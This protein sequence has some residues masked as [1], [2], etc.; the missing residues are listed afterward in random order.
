MALTQ[1][2]LLME[3][4]AVDVLSAARETPL[5]WAVQGGH[6]P[7]VRTLLHWGAK[8]DVKNARGQTPTAVVSTDSLKAIMT[9]DADSGKQFQQLATLPSS[10][11]GCRCA[12]GVP[13]GAASLEAPYPRCRWSLTSWQGLS[14]MHSSMEFLRRSSSTWRWPVLQMLLRLGSSK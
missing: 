2:I 13:T 10:F 7:C 14:R 5:F 8:R 12:P 11:R 9:G 4:A 6:E 1:V 3:A